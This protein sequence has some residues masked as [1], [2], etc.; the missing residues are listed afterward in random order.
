M[1]LGPLVAPQAPPAGSTCG[2]HL[3]A[4]PAGSTCSP[5]SVLRWA[6]LRRLSFLQFFI[7]LFAHTLPFV[8]EK[9]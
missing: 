9:S 5:C 2:L 8:R 3:Q 6:R 4:P 7:I 1:M